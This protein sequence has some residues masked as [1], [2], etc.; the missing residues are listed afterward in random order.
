MKARIVEMKEMNGEEASTSG[1]RLFTRACRYS[2]PFVIAAGMIVTVSSGKSQDGPQPDRSIILPE[3]NRP[4]DPNDRMK[5]R[6]QNAKKLNYDAANAARK[7]QLDDETAK[8]LI[9]AKD[10]KAQTD[11]IGASPLTHKAVKEAEVIEML[12]RDVK[13]KMKLSVGGS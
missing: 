3:A 5:L 1:R 8:L 7:R 11:N 10:L 9:L 13:E 12:A 2:I 4:L 6:E